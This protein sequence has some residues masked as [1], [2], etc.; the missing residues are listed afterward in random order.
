MAVELYFRIVLRSKNIEQ[1]TTRWI[2][3]GWGLPF[4][5]LIALSS[6]K[7]CACTDGQSSVRIRITFVPKVGPECRSVA[8]RG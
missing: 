4:I 1:Y 2:I 6:G 3:A 7:A 5:P 8:T